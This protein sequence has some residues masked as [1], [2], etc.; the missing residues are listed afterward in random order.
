MRVIRLTQMRL[1][2]VL[3]YEQTTGEFR[4]KINHRNA[5]IECIAGSLNINGYHNIMIDG[6][7]YKAHRLAWL[8]VYGILPKKQL[9]HINGVKN[10]NRICNLRLATHAQNQMNSSKYSN[11]K[12]G[13]KGVSWFGPRQKWRARSNVNKKA[14]LIGYYDTP[15]IAFAAY[16]QFISV[17]HGEFANAS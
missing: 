6:V 5:P 1:H 11:N 8:Y 16:C 12:S 10:D 17:Y 4:W 9:D 3:Q 13:F 7:S 15:E 14:Y 2:E